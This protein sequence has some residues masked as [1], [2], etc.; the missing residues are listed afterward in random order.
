MLRNS[1]SLFAVVAV[2]VVLA[3][4]STSWAA[5]IFTGGGW[6]VSVGD[7]LVNLVS[8]HED[9]AVGTD[10]RILTIGITKDFIQRIGQFGEMSSILMSFRQ[11]A[12]DA[13]T[14]SR[15]VI[16]DELVSNHTGV[17]WTDFHWI[18]VQSGYASFNQ[19]ETYPATHAGFST[20]P[21]VDHQW[22]QS[23]GSQELDVAGGVLASGSSFNP[24]AT[25]ELVI[26]T[27]LAA[28]GELAIGRFTL[29]EI[30]TIPEPM[31][32]SLLAIGGLCMAMRRKS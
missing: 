23:N 25:G 8:V 31:T 11:I 29:K 13:Q 4:S 17:A 27:N 7:D 14:A 5:V 28:D 19:N 21:F 9:E 22:V 30:P 20:D 24:G 2:A 6:Q 3:I 12:P 18:L 15:I 1:R 32:L 10:G 16:A 26:D